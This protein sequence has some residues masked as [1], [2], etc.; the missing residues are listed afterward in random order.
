MRASNKPRHDMRSPPQSAERERGMGRLAGVVAGRRA[1][2]RADV[3]ARSPL[4]RVANERGGWA[5]HTS[6][7]GQEGNSGL[8]IGRGWAGGAPPPPTG[9]GGGGGWGKE[10]G[11]GGRG[12]RAGRVRRGPGGGSR[13]FL[14][15]SKL[16]LSKKYKSRERGK[17]HSIRC[18]RRRSRRRCRFPPL[19]P[20]SSGREDAQATP[21]AAAARAASGVGGAEQ[22]RRKPAQRKLRG[23][24]I[25]CGVGEDYD[26]AALRPHRQ[27]AHPVHHVQQDSER[28]V[29]RNDP[30]AR[31]VEPCAVLDLPRCHE[32]GDRAGTAPREG[33]AQNEGGGGAERHARNVH[34]S[35]GPRP[36]AGV[37]VRPAPEERPRPLVRV[38]ADEV[39]RAG[40]AQRLERSTPA[41]SSSIA[42]THPA[43]PVW[44]AIIRL[45][46]PLG[47][48]ASASAPPPLLPSS[49]SPPHLLPPRRRTRTH[50]A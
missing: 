16:H 20:T 37:H 10:G 30:S 46:C 39:Q 28:R 5:Q 50:S 18:T 12:G 34:R 14:F 48:A 26:G 8:L 17:A 33:G 45:V 13:L 15:C 22:G 25:E 21:P 19:P 32:S 41:L 40:P 2:G 31:P 27:R 47:R 36:Q 1:G 9:G 3:A 24:R 7:S 42:R 4:R 11:G 44:R 43:C 38:E 23:V 49:F 6:P 35:G 29:P